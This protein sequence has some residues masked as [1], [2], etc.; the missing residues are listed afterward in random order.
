M[1][2]GHYAGLEVRDPSN[3]SFW[4]FVTHLQLQLVFGHLKGTDPLEST[5]SD[6]LGS[7]THLALDFFVPQHEEN[8]ENSLTNVRNVLP[9]TL[10]LCVLGLRIE[11]YKL[12]PEVLAHLDKAWNGGVDERIVFWSHP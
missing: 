7:V 12:T 1:V 2:L 10:K 11:A 8:I 3:S 6:G 4:A 5:L 9:S